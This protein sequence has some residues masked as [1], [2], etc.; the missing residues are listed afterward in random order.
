MI[1][2]SLLFYVG[3][4][5]FHSTVHLLW[6]KHLR[7][8]TP[9]VEKHIVYCVDRCCQADIHVMMD[10][11]IILLFQVLLAAGVHSEYEDLMINEGFAVNRDMFLSPDQTFLYVVTGSKVSRLLTAV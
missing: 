2:T 6:R 9:G 1:F 8:F 10:D 5:T 3:Y 4:I 11:S 7:P